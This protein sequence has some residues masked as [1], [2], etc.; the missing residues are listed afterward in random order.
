MNK[1]RYLAL[2]I[3]AASLVGAQLLDASGN[4]LRG[5]E[6]DA[7]LPPVDGF[8]DLRIDLPT[9]RITNWVSPTPAYLRLFQG[10]L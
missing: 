3:E 5:I 6:I 8:V 4:V 7:M 9:G 10:D 1:P 2:R